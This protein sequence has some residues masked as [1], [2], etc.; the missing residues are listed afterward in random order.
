L[1]VIKVRKKTLF[2][3]GLLLFLASM[4]AM[5]VV[6]VN[7]SISNQNWIGPTYRGSDSFLG[8]SVTAYKTGSTATLVVNV[9]SDYYVGYPYYSDR[10]VNISAV[11]VCPDWNINYTSTEASLGSPTVIQ[12]NE[13]RLFT[14]TFTMPDTAIASNLIANNY[15]IYVEQVN[16]TTGAKRIV[17]TWTYSGSE[18]AVYSTEQADSM[19]IVQKY[20]GI[21]TPSFSYPEARVLWTEA[22]L[23]LSIGAKSYQM[24]NFTDA[25]IHYQAMDSLFQ[26][27]LQT[28][29]TK[30]AAFTD[31]QTYYYNKTADAVTMQSYG[32]ILMGLGLTLFGVGAIIYGLRRR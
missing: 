24:G 25:K 19:L 21:S 22:Q 5:N 27:A 20:S 7:A 6:T 4:T 14:I 16:S 13:Y 15:R 9:Y 31:S 18:L 26:Q 11:K 30:G 2:C 1:R 23:E 8:T 32:Y 17:N 3:I 29:S 28:E 10:P 12:P